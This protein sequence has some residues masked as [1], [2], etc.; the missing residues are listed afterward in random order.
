MLNQPI[1]YNY[2]RS[3]TSVRVRIGLNLKGIDYKYVS[4]HLRKKEHQTEEYLKINSYGLLPTIEFPSGIKL[5]QSLAI[6]EY[7]DEI[8][9]TPSII[10]VNP[11]DRAKVRSMAYAIALE[12]HPLNNLHVLNY[13]KED[14][15][16][17]DLGV[18]NWFSKW[19]HKAFMP[20]ENIL[21]ND[22]DAGLYCFGSTPTLVDIC[23]FAQVV[24][25]ARFEV[26]MTRYPKI[27]SVYKAC[28]NNKAFYD[29]L[30][31]NQ[32]DAE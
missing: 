2:F 16:L 9:P 32:P 28:L 30:P 12:I 24:N 22:K 5:N 20:F 1:L 7:L 25:N 8:Y 11:L 18:K 23:L 10:P 14:L 17:D 29:A 3:S 15:A 21:Q 4:L 6:L 26:D 19:V 31:K 27:N 13:L